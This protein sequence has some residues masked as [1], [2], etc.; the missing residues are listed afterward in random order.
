ML[1]LIT[2]SLWLSSFAAGA[3]AF[4]RC[5][6]FGI[7]RGL[8]SVM[9]TLSTWSITVYLLWLFGFDLKVGTIH[10]GAMA[11]HWWLPPLTLFWT[12]LSY[13]SFKPK[14]DTKSK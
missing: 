5:K 1:V 7:G 4:H 6:G 3:Y 12:A 9:V 11:E 14:D 10:D 2:L 8:V 13:W